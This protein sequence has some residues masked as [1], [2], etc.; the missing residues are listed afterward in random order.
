MAFCKKVKL[1]LNKDDNFKL[2]HSIFTLIRS[3][4][5][6]SFLDNNKFLIKAIIE[7]REVNKLSKKKNANHIIPG[8]NAA[9]SQGANVGYQSQFE[10]EVANE[11]LTEMERQNNKKTK[12]RQ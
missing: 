8:A 5:Y 2:S 7:Q 4:K 12:K 3:L 9:K 10:A 6:I 1:S 11:P